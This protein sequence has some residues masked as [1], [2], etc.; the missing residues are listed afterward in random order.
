M[1]PRTS[2]ALRPPRSRS[3]KAGFSLRTKVRMALLTT[4]LAAILGLRLIPG[5]QA[6]MQT[7]GAPGRILVL[8]VLC[9]P[10]VT[11]FLLHRRKPS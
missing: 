4:T 1:V 10:V 2:P 6:W 11:V 9:L 3:A 8:S 5:L 7:Q